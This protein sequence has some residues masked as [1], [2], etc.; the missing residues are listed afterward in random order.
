MKTLL[1][2]ML[3]MSLSASVWASS[4]S[5]EQYIERLKAQARSEGISAQ[6]IAQAFHNVEYKP[7]AVKAD[8]NQPEKTDSG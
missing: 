2:A 6:T 3:G 1:T 7:R 5:F 8:R 4:E